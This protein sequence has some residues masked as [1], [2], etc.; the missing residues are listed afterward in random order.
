M[1][2]L[3]QVIATHILHFSFLILCLYFQTNT[4]YNPHPQEEKSLDIKTKKIIKKT[5]QTK[6]KL[7]WE[8]ER[9][10]AAVWWWLIGEGWLSKILTADLISI[11][12]MRKKEKNKFLLLLCNYLF[13]LYGI[14]MLC[15]H[16]VRDC[17]WKRGFVFLKRFLIREKKY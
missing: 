6:L 2:I 14:V 4:R 10:P 8:K 11:V 3:K 7:K 5:I 15:M 13:K 16:N 9:V 17:L 12:V 1:I